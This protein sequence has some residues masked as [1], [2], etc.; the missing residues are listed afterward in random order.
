[1]G[2]LFKKLRIIYLM[3]LGVVAILASS[4]QS[5]YIGYAYPAGAGQGSTVQVNIGGQRIGDVREINISGSGVHPVFVKYEGPNGPLKNV[6]QDEL[7]RQLN[8]LIDKFKPAPEVTATLA[9]ANPPA[10]VPAVPAVVTAP[11]P[12]VKLPDLPE[13]RDLDKMTL[14]QLR[15]VFDKFLNRQ[16]R[17]KPPIAEDVTINVT[18]DADAMPGDRVLRVRTAA[19]LSNPIIFQVSKL[20]EVNEKDRNDPEATAP[21]VQEAPVVLNGQ[22]MPGEMDSYP[23]L[24]KAGQKLAI[25]ANARKLIPYLA[26]AVPGW[27]QAS[28]ALTDEKGKELA[29]ACDNR[30]D[31]DPVFFYTVPQDG[32]YFLRIRDSLY[33]GREDF[34]YR[35][36]LEQQTPG[37]TLYPLQSLA[38]VVNGDILAQIPQQEEAEPNDNIANAQKVAVPE[39]IKGKIGRDGDV[40]LYK[41]TGKAGDSLVAEVY[42]R[43]L[44][45]PLDS[46]VRLLDAT[47]KVIALNDDVKNGE[48][49]L[50]TNYTDSY[51]QA[52]LPADGT[53]FV[54]VSNT[55]RQGGDD[56]NYY[57]RISPP[58]GDFTVCV[59]PSA[60]NLTPGTPTVFTAYAF[61]KD[62]W[63]GDIDITLKD[64][65]YQLSGARIPKGL[66]SVRMTMTLIPP[67]KVING[68]FVLGLEG[69]AVIAGKTV[70]RPVLAAE[71]EMQAFAYMHL[72]PEGQLH[73]LAKRGAIRDY[74]TLNQA[75]GEK[76]H[77][78]SGGELKVNLP[79]KAGQTAPNR[80]T[81]LDPPAGITLKDVAKSPTGVTFTLVADDKHVGYADNLIIEAFLDTDIPATATTK[82]RT[83]HT[84]LGILSAVAFEV[85]K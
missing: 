20:A 34:V 72:V 68:P 32:N 41:F 48:L 62:G 63:D 83:T 76:I 46:L 1:M 84:S 54:Q 69:R 18:V 51:L 66:D 45:S 67:Q 37:Q 50:L 43:R 57:L 33:R 74:L 58:Q 73:I 44:G 52:K 79:L 56:Y 15:Q 24:L 26:D 22:I 55:L 3:L 2:T 75:A 17:T 39:L 13:L 27:F 11:P 42:A 65:R 40:D 59:S 38:S 4:A 80:L 10:V 6:Q 31:P 29:Y 8:I 12:P 77:V 61:R 9:P 71:H 7:K 47:G 28:I 5:P 36:Y 25:T 81:L 64:A 21:L 35:I 70:T 60:L 16:K 14:K 78:P 49:G 30:F 53:Y 85:V 23:L 19:G 82:A